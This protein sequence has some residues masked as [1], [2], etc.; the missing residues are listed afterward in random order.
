MA[1]TILTTNNSLDDNN[2]T[3]GE[4]LKLPYYCGEVE[5]WMVA[6]NVFF[7]LINIISCLVTLVANTLFLVVYFRT[8]ALRNPHYF[9]LML[10][11]ITD[12]S[13]GLIS[14]P[15]FIA[16]KFMEIYTVHDCVLWTAMRASV[17]Y[18][19]GISFLTITLVSIERWFAVCRPIKHRRDV[20]PKR[21]AVVA[22]IVWLIWFIFPVVR[23]AVPK[24]YRAFGMLV[25][26]IIVAIFLINTRLYVKIQRSV[27]EGK[28]RFAGKEE[29][30]SSKEQVN[31]KKEGRMA[32]TVAV[33]LVV[34]V[35]A[36]L[37][38]AIGLTYKALRGVNTLYLF[39]F[40]PLADTLV[41]I[42]SSFNPLFYCYRNRNIRMAIKKR[43]SSR[44]TSSMN[45][46]SSANNQSTSKI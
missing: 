1:A 27:R 32:K 15:L 31:F 35:L 13:V 39:V 41:L 26:G 46:D 37:P 29:Q 19:S 5:S 2:T 38:T 3:F 4:C 9:F 11:A 36:Y 7:I 42:N 43:M 30:K 12:I 16:R 20:T 21:M 45:C 25:G 18:F 24:F 33:L 10:L 14:Q 17:Y 6:T 22:F 44:T 28:L 34:M 23:F 8:R 40:L